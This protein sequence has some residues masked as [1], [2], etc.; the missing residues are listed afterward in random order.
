MIRRRKLTPTEEEARRAKNREGMR[1][2][3]ERQRQE[4]LQLKTT[5]VQLE[6]QYANLCD[7]ASTSGPQ[8]EPE[9]DLTLPRKTCQERNYADMVVMAKQLGAEKLLLLDMLKQKAAWTL[10][11]QRVLDFESSSLAAYEQFQESPTVDIDTL[12][13]IQAEEEL[14]FHPLNE[15]DLTR[16]ILDNKRDIHHVENRLQPETGL[17]ATLGDKRTHRMEAFGWEIVQRVE[18][19]TMEFLFSKKF[20]GLSVLD[21]MHKTWTNDIKLSRFQTVKAET[22]RLEVLQQMN[23]NAFVFVRDV[24]SP[25]DISIFRSVF[26]HFL[27]EASKEFPI[28]DADG[29][30][31]TLTGT[32][33]VLGTQSIATDHPRHATER[34]AAGPKIA[35]ANLALTTE[36]YDVVDPATDKQEARRVKNREGM[37]KARERHRHELL[38]MK[39]TLA[40]LEK[41]H[42][43]L[44]RRAAATGKNA[45]LT[46]CNHLPT[47]ED[48]GLNPVE[49][50]R[51]LGAEKLH[52]QAILKQKIAWTMQIQRV[53]DFE[54]SSLAA[55]QHFQ[56]QQ[57]ITDIDSMGETLARQELDF[58]PIT[59]WDLTRF[60][61]DNKCMMH[62]VESR[63]RLRPELKEQRSHRVQAFGWDIVQQVQGSVMEF[64]FTKKFTN[65][66]V[67]DVMHKTWTNDINLSRFKTVKAETSRLEVLQQIN[68]NAVVFVRDVNSFGDIS[69]FRSV[70]VHFLV[71]ASREFPIS[72]ADGNQQTLTGTGFVLGTQSIATDHSRHATERDAAGRKIAWANL[73]LTTEAYDV[74]DPATGEHY[75]QVVWAGRTDYCTEEDAHRNA[76]DTLQGL[77]RWEMRMVAPAL[78]L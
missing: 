21:I 76:A 47:E 14:G 12:D 24:D 71:E 42:A 70:F 67:F 73:A 15:W 51:R 50:A 17:L 78:N 20:S 56:P 3:R 35:W 5:V 77:L 29:N 19:N 75:Q 39:T 33:F 9:T 62:H 38:L 10:Q 65:F 59:E 55:E 54:A 61:L 6:S 26:V 66:N 34:D 23:P 45:T 52:L 27:V 57:P 2:I 69:V 7:R 18:G 37:R 41:Q 72:D 74:V 1:K 30:Q 11:I 40:Q 48:D 58:H 63:L 16:T 60:I 49:M 36:A 46:A 28:S 44:T 13:E 22:S 43:E 25:G 53:L 31:Q 8:R 32:G 64:V 4:L 68:P